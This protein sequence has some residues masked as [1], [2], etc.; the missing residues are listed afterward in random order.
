MAEKLRT[1]DDYAPSK[2][3]RLITLDDFEPPKIKTR[4]KKVPPTESYWKYV[5]MGAVIVVII[6]WLMWSREHFSSR[7]GLGPAVFITPRNPRPSRSTKDELYVGSV[8]TTRLSEKLAWRPIEAQEM[9]NSDARTFP[10]RLSV[11][12][13]ESFLDCEAKVN[14]QPTLIRGSAVW[15]P[16]GECTARCV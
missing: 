12:T 14:G 15:Y 7:Y 11:G 10:G 4:E 13:T 3:D 6:L 1:L 16:D 8:Y 9:T 2:T 5:V